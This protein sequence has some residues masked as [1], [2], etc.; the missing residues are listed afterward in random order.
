MSDTK[1]C[2]YCGEEIQA[3][4]K[5]C[6]YCG[7]WL[8]KTTPPP[9]PR[10]LPTPNNGGTLANANDADEEMTKEE[11]LD[12]LNR[13]N[14]EET[15]GLLWGCGWRLALAIAAIWFVCATVPD[16]ADHVEAIH[17]EARDLIRDHASSAVD[18]VLPGLGTFL[19]AL[20]DS[21][22]VDN[23]LDELFDLRNSI[24]VDKGWF[25]STGYVVNESY[26]KGTLASF[27]ICGIVIPLVTW[28]DIRILSDKEK[29]NFVGGN[30]ENDEEETTSDSNTA[31]DAEPD[32]TGESSSQITDWSMINPVTLG[33]DK[34]YSEWRDNHSDLMHQTATGDID[35]YAIHVDI[36]HNGNHIVGRYYNDANGSTALDLNGTSV[37]ETMYLQLGHGSQISHAV[38]RKVKGTAHTWRGTWGKSDKRM[39]LVFSE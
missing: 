13:R 37:G 38:L 26:P 7:E 36:M 30:D 15:A 28:D 11:A 21:K 24:K 12:W 16:E 31:D 25:W 39:E 27:G 20:V 8:D 10:T 6:R 3:S 32:D 33:S 18:L 17:E 19:N 35:G 22:D 23:S 34:A 4:A 2:P 1:T 9:A 14:G 5:K 29:S